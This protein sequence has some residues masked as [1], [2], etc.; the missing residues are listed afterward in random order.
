[1]TSIRNESARN[2]LGTLLRILRGDQDTVAQVSDSWQE[3]IASMAFFSK[4]FAYNSYKDIQQLYDEAM[5]LGFNIDTTLPSEIASSAL[6]TSDL[7]RAISTVQ[8][9]AD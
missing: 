3:Y 8:L 2:G 7:P 6:F 9:K 4:P 5:D 1:V